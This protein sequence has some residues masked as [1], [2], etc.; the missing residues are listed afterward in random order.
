MAH[1][2]ERRRL[3]FERR[4]AL[5]DVL[6]PGLRLVQALVRSLHFG[7]QLHQLAGQ[8]SHAGVLP[9]LLAEEVGH[10]QGHNNVSEC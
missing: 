10:L 6:D 5:K 3:G 9:A 2:L 8:R 7:L 1:L 4:N